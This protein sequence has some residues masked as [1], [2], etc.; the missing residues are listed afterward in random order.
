MQ[1]TSVGCKNST[2]GNKTKCGTCT[3]R[4]YRLR[5]PIKAAYNNLRNNARRRGKE[6]SITFEYFKEFCTET[7]YIL[8]KGKTKES[9]TIDRKVAELGYIPGNLQVLTNRNNV[10]K[11]HGKP[12]VVLD[13]FYDHE[14]GKMEFYTHVVLEQQQS[15]LEEGEQE[16]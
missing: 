15:N 9:Y 4:A 3:S 2:V 12:Y 14:N 1:C 10:L 7:N 6:F 16:F 13:Y 5:H 8:G 11:R